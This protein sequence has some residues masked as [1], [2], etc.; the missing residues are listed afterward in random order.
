MFCRVLITGGSGLLAMNWALAMR[1]YA[2]VCLLTH[3][4]SVSIA[5]VSTLQ[6]C[7]DEKEGLLEIVSEWQPDLIVHTAGIANVDL[8]ER[9]PE[10]AKYVNGTLAGVVASVANSLSIPF[11]HIST[12]HRLVFL[13]DLFPDGPGQSAQFLL[14]AAD[15]L[16]VC[17]SGGHHAPF[18]RRTQCRLLRNLADTAG[19]LCPGHS[20]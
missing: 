2:A 13:C 14:H 20:R 12:D 11:I 9:E 5:G 1:D 7:L 4:H 15:C 18:F 10:L 3:T 17:D 19:N 16:C 8:C 6:T